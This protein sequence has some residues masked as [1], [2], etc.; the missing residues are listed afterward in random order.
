ML[1]V[2]EAN[3]GAV[4]VQT[5]F[6]HVI[7]DTQGIAQGRDGTLWFTEPGEFAIGA[8]SKAGVLSRFT[9]RG[10]AVDIAL[11]P[12]GSMWFTDTIH[13]KSALGHITLAGKVEEWLPHVLPEAVLVGIAAG[14]D[15]NMWVIDE[16]GAIGRL[17][18]TGNVTWFALDG[19]APTGGLVIG[20]D[21]NLWFA[22]LA[23]RPPYRRLASIATNGHVSL[24][25]RPISGTGYYATRTNDGSVWFT[26]YD[27]DG[28]GRLTPASQLIEYH[29]GL[30]P[31]GIPSGITVGP[32]GALWFMQAGTGEIGRIDMGGHITE[33][34][35]NISP[36]GRPGGIATGPD[37]RMWFTQV[38][39]PGLG[40][41]EPVAS[42]SCLVPRLIGLPVSQARRALKRSG[43][44]VGRVTVKG[45]SSRGERR[46]RSQRPQAGNNGVA[47]LR[48]SLIVTR[49]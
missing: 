5:R 34:E 1:A 17:T 18:P 47:G 49:G 32:D 33:Y 28:I 13:D 41:I 24:F 12:D 46:V 10:R 42:P 21:G 7:S 29:A 22:A 11:A 36:G 38:F 8:L 44:A 19:L 6:Q 26:E 4:T 31:G 40:Q 3:A 37:G 25:P 43:C 30:T 48:V 16:A 15:G 23:T 27:P 2:G 14:P 35:T 9:T 39:A 45:R 20:P